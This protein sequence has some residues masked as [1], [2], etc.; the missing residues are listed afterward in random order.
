MLGG[1]TTYFLAMTYDGN[2]LVL[3]VGLVG[4]ALV[5]T[6]PTM[7]PA[8]TKFQPV[9]QQSGSVPLFIGL[10]RPDLPN[11]RFPIDASI[12]DVAVYSDALSATD[13]QGARRS[14]E[15]DDGRSRPEAAGAAPT[16]RRS[17]LPAQSF[18]AR[19]RL[20]RERG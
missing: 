18:P 10:G 17:S 19:T 11:G 15:L 20:A 5:A 8:N 14:A 12:Q 16:W 6:P 3:Y 7:N 13:I 1:N 9:V 2:A 4:G